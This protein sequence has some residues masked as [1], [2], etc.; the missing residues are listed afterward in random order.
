MSS[1]FNKGFLAPR[2]DSSHVES[3]ARS[4]RLRQLESFIYPRPNF[5]DNISPDTATPPQSLREIID[6]IKEN[7]SIEKEPQWYRFYGDWKIATKLM[8]IELPMRFLGNCDLTWIIPSQ[9]S[10]NVLALSTC[11]GRVR[12]WLYILPDRVWVVLYVYWAVN[13][14]KYFSLPLPSL[15][16]LRLTLRLNSPALYIPGRHQTWA[17]SCSLQIVNVA[18][19][20]A[21][22]STYFA[23]YY[24]D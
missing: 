5:A 1:A 17:G 16:Y 3:C 9:S 20:H 11:S 4:L 15:S 24:E 2:Q 7:L 14:H 13:D 23:V 22:C 10:S 12:S 18:A 6:R 19:S 8:H 21:I